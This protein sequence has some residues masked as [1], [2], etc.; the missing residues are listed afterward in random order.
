MAAQLD[1]FELYKISREFA[2]GSTNSMKQLPPAEKFALANQMRRAAIS[3]KQIAEGHVDAH[4]REHSFL[5]ITRGSVDELIDDSMSVWMK[6]TGINHPSKTESR[7]Y[8]LIRRINGD[9]GICEK[10]TGH[11]IITTHHSPL[12]T[13]T[14]RRM[15]PTNPQ[16]SRGR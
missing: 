9:I 1:D 7:G 12:T 13:P 5:C 8:D 6:S 3:V 10:E 15:A 14:H 2:N 4:T 11:R 16:C